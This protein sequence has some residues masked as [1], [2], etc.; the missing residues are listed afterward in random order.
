MAAYSPG[1]AKRKSKNEI[2]THLFFSGVKSEVIFGNHF[3]FGV[4]N[5][6]KLADIL[7]RGVK[8]EKKIG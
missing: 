5:E 7:V 1:E 4:K 3:S 6:K 8:N 2:P